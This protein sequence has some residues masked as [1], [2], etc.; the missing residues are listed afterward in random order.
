MQQNVQYAGVC[1]FVNVHA[2]GN[3]H[4]RLSSTAT[5]IIPEINSTGVG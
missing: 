1:S 2:H 3:S 4:K 5:A